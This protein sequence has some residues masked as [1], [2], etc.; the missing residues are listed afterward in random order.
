MAYRALHDLP[1][2]QHTHKYTH[3]LTNSHLSAPQSPGSSHCGL[4]VALET[5]LAHACLRTFALALH[6]PGIP[7][8]YVASWLTPSFSSSLC[9]DVNWTK[10]T[11]LAILSEIAPS[12]TLYPFILLFLLSIYLFGIICSLTTYTHTLKWKLH[13]GR[14]LSVHCYSPST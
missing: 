1:L 6:M 10:W 13:E 9:S 11:S 4:F 3:V 14:V 7:F 2:P 8:H 5:H 12:V